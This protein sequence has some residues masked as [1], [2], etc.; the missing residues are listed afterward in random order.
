MRLC[1]TDVGNA[2]QFTCPFHGW[3][4]A[5]NGTLIG[6]P[7]LKEAYFGEIDRGHWGL[8]EVPRVSSYGGFIFGN[9]DPGSIDLDGYLGEMRWYLDILINRPMGG[10]RCCGDDS[11]TNVNQTGK[12]L[13][14]TLPETPIT[15]PIPMDRYS[16]LMRDGSIRLV[17]RARRTSTRSR[18][19]MGT[20]YVQFPRR[21]SASKPTLRLAR[22]MGAEVIDYVE[23]TQRCLIE[24][25]KKQQVGVYTI[26]FGN[27]F[28]NFSLNNFS[29][30]RPI[31]LYL[32]HPRGPTMLEAWQW[33]AVD[34]EAPTAV[35]EIIRVDF[36]RRAGHGR[37]SGAGRH[38]ELRAGHRSHPR[39]CRPRIRIQL[40]DGSWP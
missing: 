37:Y 30:L 23:Q 19:I 32:W 15:C 17:T 2:A 39:S 4:Y 28:P 34:S 38:R 1:R 6:V 25:L 22:E 14:R 5:S 7:F 9:M 18:L 29:A 12:S 26:G 31:G 24:Q 21:A 3:T 8:F 35:K 10:S 33:C 13:V 11:D 36:A 16:A 40:P 20:A 27:I